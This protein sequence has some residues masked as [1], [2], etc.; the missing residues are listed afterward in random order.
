MEDLTVTTTVTSL[1]LPPSHYC[2][3]HRHITVT[4]TITLL[5]LPP[6][7]YCYYHRHITVTTTVTLLLL[8]PSHYC[9]YNR[10]FTVSVTT[11][12]IVTDAKCNRQFS[13]F[14]FQCSG[15]C[16]IHHSHSRPTHIHHFSQSSNFIIL[17]TII[18][19]F[20]T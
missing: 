10:H 9:F 8:R 19:M 6:S 2:Y 1:L 16:H 14:L 13:W 18:K 15:N 17:T 5:L 12:I 11:N 4:T 7:H 20:F 3:Y